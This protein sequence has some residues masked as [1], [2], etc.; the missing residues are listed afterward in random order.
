MTN[1]HERPLNIYEQFGTCGWG[2]EHDPP[3]FTVCSAVG[4]HLRKEKF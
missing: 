2:S 1:R 4:A 3:N